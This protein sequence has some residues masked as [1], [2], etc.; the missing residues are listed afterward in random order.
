[1]PL[2]VFVALPVPLRR[3]FDYLALPDQVM[4]TAG[5]RVEVTFG[6]QLLVGVVVGCGEASVSPDKLKTVHR[7]LDDSPLLSVE[8][9]DLCQ[10]CADYYQHP[11]GE[12]LH[13]ALPI[14]FR[15]PLPALRTTHRVW[16]H[17]LEGKGLP[18]DA[19]KRSPKQQHAH[20][21]LLEHGELDETRLRV[22]NISIAAL[23]ALMK[24]RLVIELQCETAYTHKHSKLLAETPLD[25]NEEQAAALAQIRF[26]SFQT[27]LLEGATGSGKTELYLQAIA[28]VLEA[29]QQVLVLV[30][31]IG[32]TPQTSERFRQR[33]AVPVVELHSNIAKKM[34]SQNWLSAA[35][36]HARIVIG[37]RLAAFTPMPHLGLI[38]LDEEHDL[39]FKQQ[40]GLRFSARDLAV[41]RAKRK[42]IPLILGS[43]TPSIESINNALC[44]RYE[45]LRLTQR[46]GGAKP[47][48]LQ[49]LDL[50]RET[51][52]EGFARTA[53]DRIKQHIQHG[54]QV[55]VFINRRGFAPAL[56]C[57]HCGWS[58][59]CTACDARMTLHS[60]P[61]HLHCHHCD[62]QK[63]VPRQCP[64]CHHPDLMAQ[65]QGTERCEE[66]LRSLFP[67]TPVIRVD[68]DSMQQKSSMQT[69]R[70]QIDQGNPCILVGTQMLAKGHHF[71]KLTLVVV[72]DVDQGLFSGDFRGTERMAQ[73]IIQV[74]GRAGRGVLAGEVILQSHRPDHPT[75]QLILQFGYHRFA[76]QL[77]EERKTTRLPPFWHLALLRAESK[78]P[79]N[80]VAFLEMAL[81]QAQAMASVSVNL[82]YLGPL[83]S[84]LE[85]RQERFRYQLQIH[86]ANRRT[87][88]Q[89]LSQWI[90]AIERHPL[91]RRTHWSLDVDPQEMS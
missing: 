34:R 74:S 17:S 41:V 38:I 79:D 5:T 27:Y 36:G 89:L 56:I 19:L 29:D 39:S 18:H 20:Q 83:P 70:E 72:F 65:G 77:L 8:L 42:G 40:D 16:R 88:Q 63:P 51:I 37:T 6:Q 76:R 78:R 87:L 80:A 50:R 11:L 33:F 84:L 60:Q 52:V 28:R 75:L 14:E 68:Q 49:L 2:V 90:V 10:W 7:V 58:A 22:E 24:K 54:G 57:H 85:K 3:T 59:G 66:T 32:L 47:P 81:K 30:P 31:E 82:F 67:Q 48:R 69:L 62:Q 46:T 44:G 53:I 13:F 35:D 25:L 64:S 4:P 26:H 61:R 71:P 1:M 9:L 43:A 86:C 23:R 73:Q 12:V 45:H 21:A 91:A 55:L 15:T